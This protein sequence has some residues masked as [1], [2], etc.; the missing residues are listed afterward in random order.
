MRVSLVKEKLTT[1]TV[2]ELLE[3]W[4]RWS[5]SNLGFGNLETPTQDNTHWITDDIAIWV[6]GAVGQL[7]MVDLNKGRLGFKN[8]LPRNKAV[9]LYYLKSHNIPMLANSLKCGEPK[10]ALILKS[11]ESFIESHLGLYEAQEKAG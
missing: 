3:Q 1:V 8:V 5:R 4:G 10:A 7:G 6:D 2:T 11:G 9:T